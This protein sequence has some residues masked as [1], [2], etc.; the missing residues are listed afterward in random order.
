MSDVGQ[1]LAVPTAFMDLL[2]ERLSRQGVTG[3]EP[4]AFVFTA[5]RGGPLDYSHWRNRVWRPAVVSV[6]LTDLTFHDLRRA[7]ATGL[8]AEG[9]DLKTAQTRLGHADHRLTL[10]IYAQATTEADRAA[11]D[12]LGARFMPSRERRPG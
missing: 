11:A 1:T 3:A 10:V 2:S 8:V 9:V 5:S 12:R 4:E 7:A 6:G